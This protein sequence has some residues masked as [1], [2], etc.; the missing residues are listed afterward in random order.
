MKYRRGFL[1]AE[2]T[3]KIVI[4]VICLL[5][6]AYLLVSIYLNNKTDEELEL[7]KA[8]LENLVNEINAGNPSVE[9]YNPD[10]WLIIPW[11]E[12]ET[13]PSICKNLG[14]KNCLCICPKT[15]YQKIYDVSTIEGRANQCSDNGICLE[16]KQ[17]IIWA[18]DMFYEEIYSPLFL[19]INYGD[20]IT[21][22]IK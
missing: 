10:G 2:E 8:S 13:I 21:L 4:A 9:I 17:K 5:F 20:E 12:P 14:W 6:L 18:N 11:S 22:K 7:A 1:L 3:L 16:S 15:W 19:E